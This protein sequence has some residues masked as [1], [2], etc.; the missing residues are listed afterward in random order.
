MTDSDDQFYRRA[1]AR[2][3]RFQQVLAGLGLL[4]CFAWKGWPTAAGFALGAILAWI[5][6]LWLK[7]I[8]DSLGSDSVRTSARSAFLFG[9]RYLILGAVAYVILRLTT[10]SIP[11]TLT[12]L[13]VS[14]GAV[15]AEIVF[16]IVY[17]RN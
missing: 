9:S 13:F 15:L 6:F 3:L 14:L 4:V 7:K 10:I 17:A 16:E 5:N 1:V 2:I 11:A 8:A 12:G